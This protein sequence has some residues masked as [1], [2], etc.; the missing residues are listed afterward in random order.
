M[1]LLAAKDADTH[2]AL[3][4]LVR[5]SPGREALRRVLDGELATDG[6][7]ISLP[8]RVDLD[9]RPRQ[10]VDPVHGKEAVTD[11]RVLAREDGRTRVALLPPYR[12]RAPVAGPRCAPDSM[13]SRSSEIGCTAARDTRASCSMR[14]HSRSSTHTQ[15]SG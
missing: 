4:K 13:A 1:L 11:W 7:T 2:R 14:K 10:I 5:D 9:D 12:T 6:G 15:A 8:L 3:Q